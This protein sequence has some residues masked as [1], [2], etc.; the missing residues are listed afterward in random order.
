MKKMNMGGKRK[1]FMAGLSA[2]LLLTGCGSAESASADSYSGTVNAMSTKNAAV[3]YATEEAYY[4]DYEAYDEA[5]MNGY[6]EPA[7]GDTPEAPE[8]AQSTKR[9]LIR[10][11]SMSVETKEFD[12]LLTT[13]QR[14]TKELGGYVESSSTD[15]GSAYSGRE[16]TRSAWM[17]VRIPADQLDLFLSEVQGAANVISHSENVNDV[18]LTYVDMESHKN[19]LRSEE[20]RLMELMEKA[21]TIE[22]LIVIENRL[23]DIRYQI[24]SMESQLRTY[25]NLVDYATLSLSISEVKELTPV[26]EL[27]S[28][29]KMGNGFM[30]SLSS[31]GRGIRDFF[32]GLVMN[33]PYLILWA[34]VIFIGVL[35]VKGVIKKLKKKHAAKYGNPAPA[36][37]YTAAA[38][39]NN[40]PAAN[41][42]VQKAA[43]AEVKDTAVKEDG[44][45]KE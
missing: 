41:T 21:E 18:T 30:N 7:G 4:D 22:D 42:E 40:A 34:V 16:M 20:E 10:N 44:K 35:I 5:G 32:I 23:T 26:K 8:S 43:P 45:K 11:V 29:E 15:N 27:S 19:A 3:T 28:W 38:V 12:E 9:K 14:R 1:L 2:I 36:V 25:D 24:E 6:A 37:Q 39:Q 31:I 33:L 17:T 13:L